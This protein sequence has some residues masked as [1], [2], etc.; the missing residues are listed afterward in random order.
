VGNHQLVGDVIMNIDIQAITVALSFA[1][2]Y[3]DRGHMHGVWVTKDGYSATDG[4]VMII[5]NPTENDSVETWTGEPLLIDLDTCKHISKWRL[6]SALSI[7]KDNEKYIISTLDN[8][9][10]IS[11][12][13]DNSVSRPDM[14]RVVKAAESAENSSENVSFNAK[15]LSMLR[16]VAR[17]FSHPKTEVVTMHPK[18]CGANLFIFRNKTGDTAKVLISSMRIQSLTTSS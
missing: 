6:S 16:P 1:Y 18:G 3:K 4:H 11:I 9:Q 13:Y 14:E 2:P 8:K 7:S 10:S 12:H 15:Y 5:I 17:Y